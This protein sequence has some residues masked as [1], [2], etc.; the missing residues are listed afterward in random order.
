MKQVLIVIIVVTAL[1]FIFGC[2]LKIFSLLIKTKDNQI[3]KK[4]NYILPQSQCRKCG[5]QNCQSYA[6]AIVMEGNE[7]NKCNP[8]GKLVVLKIAELLNIKPSEINLNKFKKEKQVAFIDEN[9]CIGCSKC[10]QNCP[11][12]VIIG[13]KHSMHTILEQFCTGCELCV[14]HCPTN[15]ITMIPTRNHNNN[16]KWNG[17]TIPIQSIKIQ[18]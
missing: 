15:C 14:T 18:T 8:G 7:I 10:I 9:N 16:K 6:E 2:I 4:I 3:I 13:T 5:H 1:F 17:I 12:D 11:V